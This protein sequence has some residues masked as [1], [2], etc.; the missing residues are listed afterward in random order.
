MEKKYKSSIFT[1]GDSKN[2]Q[3]KTQ[4]CSSASNELIETNQNSTILLNNDLITVS[5]DPLHDLSKQK[6][7]IKSSK[8]VLLKIVY[9]KFYLWIITIWYLIS[10]KSYHLWSFRK[11]LSKFK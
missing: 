3:K 5:I 8:E 7:V 11:C 9:L 4:V 2:S 10:L 6:Q 1:H